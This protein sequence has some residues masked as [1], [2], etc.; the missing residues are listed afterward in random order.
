M[1]GLE[2]T[3]SFVDKIDYREAQ[4]LFVT[5]CDD[6][7]NRFFTKIKKIIIFIHI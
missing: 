6:S 1:I 3:L 2:T 4:S 7:L 5:F